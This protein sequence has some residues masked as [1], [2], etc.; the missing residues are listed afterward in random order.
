MT[1]KA[2][3]GSSAWAEEGVELRTSL[4]ARLQLDFYAVGASSVG[5]ATVTRAGSSTLPKSAIVV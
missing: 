5:A 1:A 4:W 3:I 2:K